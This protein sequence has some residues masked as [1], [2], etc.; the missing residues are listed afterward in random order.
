MSAQVR[1]QDGRLRLGGVIHFENADAICKEGLTL[2][3][4]ASSDI[5][6]DLRELESGGTVD[7]AILMQWLRAAI[8]ARKQLRF[9]HASA[10]L[11]AIIRVSGL[12]DVLT[13]VNQ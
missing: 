7:V 12:S 11:K 6:V 3:S 9:D 5:V 2:I 13:Q 4:Q 10:K 1:L 8:E